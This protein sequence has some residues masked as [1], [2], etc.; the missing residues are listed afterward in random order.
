MCMALIRKLLKKRKHLTIHEKL[1]K[2]MSLQAEEAAR[3]TAFQVTL[4]AALER[5]RKA[6]ADQTNATPELTAAVTAMG[7]AVAQADAV[8]PVPPPTP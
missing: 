6:L 1:D 8:V 2:I 5:I 3:L 7:D 4:L